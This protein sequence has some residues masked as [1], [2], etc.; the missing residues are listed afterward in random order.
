MEKI[1]LYRKY[2]PVDFNGIYGQKSVVQALINSIQYDRVNHAYIFAGNKGSGKTSLAKIFSKAINCLQP[3]KGNP[4]NNCESCNSVNDNV[5]MDIIE[6]DAAS[7]SGINEIKN[8]IE[9]IVFMPTQMKYRVYIIDEAHML[10]TN[11]WNALLKTLE[12]PPAHAI[13]IFATTEYHKIPATIVSRCQRYDFSK[14]S[15]NLLVDLIC[16]V[17]KKENIVIDKDSINT[18]ALLAN[19]A[20]RDALSILDQLVNYTNNH[21][22]VDLINSMFGLLDTTTK[23]EYINTIID[24]KV[25]KAINMIDQFSQSGINFNIL[26]NDVIR[27]MMDK[28]IHLLTKDLKFMEILDTNT[29]DLIKT[30][31][32]DELLKL[33]SIY[34]DNANKLKNTEHPKFMFEYISILACNTDDVKSDDINIPKDEVK[35][36]FKPHIEDISL[37]NK[38]E[39]ENKFNVENIKSVQ[40]KN[41]NQ[42]TL[43]MPE[44]A[45]DLFNTSARMV[46]K[47]DEDLNLKQKEDVPSVLKQKNDDNIEMQSSILT[48]PL[49]KIEPS[50][51]LGQT[52]KLNTETKLT[53]KMNVEKNDTKEFTIK[54]PTDVNIVF[55]NIYNDDYKNTFFAIASNHNKN[56]KENF[57]QLLN[58]FKEAPIIS[59]PSLNAFL[60]A[61]KFLITSPNG[62]VLL[63]D[64]EAQV[65]RFNKI[66][67]TKIF[68]D[69]FEQLFKC[70]QVVIGVYKLQALGLKNEY[71]NLVKKE[72][73]DV[74]IN[75]VLKDVKKTKLLDI[76]NS[77]NVTDDEDNLE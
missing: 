70:K 57:N 24:H 14:I 26:M 10:T 35:M 18:I 12:E 41:N 11:S 59:D 51:N 65:I 60:N 67:N 62:A 28:M 44:I 46:L 52:K 32:T 74:K 69:F 43:V 15:F 53:K 25:D 54:S 58:D 63:F 27:I 6:L 21:I 8:I 4:C 9:S 16:D 20:A 1:A 68:A 64:E 50:N 71:Q 5:C 42:K 55:D 37:R 34:N 72:F 61:E 31:N 33:I 56:K 40:P 30:K 13:L 29:I 38:S 17:A 3:I 75:N 48:D 73:K 36:V 19:G 76:L 47:P 2:R 7:N 66:S 22:T 23:A 45:N 39:D 77:K 49:D